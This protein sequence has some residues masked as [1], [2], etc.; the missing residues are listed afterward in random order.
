MADLSYMYNKDTFI[1]EV[2]NERYI[3]I[4][5][6]YGVVRKT[7]DYKT[8][9]S[10]STNGRI[11]IVT[12]L[13]ETNFS[14]QF[15]N[16]DDAI[17]ALSK[18]MTT[19][20]Q[21]KNGTYT[22]PSMSVSN[23]VTDLVDYSL[24]YHSSNFIKEVKNNFIQIQDRLGTKVQYSIDYKVVTSVITNNRFLVIYRTNLSKISLQFI[25]SDDA[26]NAMNILMTTIDELKDN[27]FIYTNTNL[28]DNIYDPDTFIVDI[29][30]NEYSVR[31]RTN[32]N[33][34]THTIVAEQV[35]SI[36]AIENL[37]KVKTEA[38]DKVTTL[39]FENSTKAIIGAEKLREAIKRIVDRIP[40]T[41]GGSTLKSYS[42]IF[43]SSTEWILN[44]SVDF[45][46]DSFSIQYYE[47]VCP[48]GV[49]C[50]EQ[51]KVKQECEGLVEINGNEET[52]ILEY[53]T[54]KF[55][56]EISGKAIIISK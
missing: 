19:I 34:I 27:T 51:D 20:S 7:I 26:I 45:D 32:K 15:V 6:T 38:T 18:L 39:A 14:L 53:I 22:N 1:K 8:F 23:N 12:K 40:I 43:D 37:V 47:Y 55:N 54:I 25:T 2:V 46:M 30:I 11:L 9:G 24:M 42:E 4:Q 29:S 49:T 3:Q 10:A 52:N 17:F 21:L 56:Q 13:D 44:P 31:I 33:I 36:Y 50:S 48:D 41:P 5:D 28:S 35:I 16:S